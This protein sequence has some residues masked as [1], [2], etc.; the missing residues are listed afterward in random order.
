VP[1][2]PTCSAQRINLFHGLSESQFSWI[3]ERLYFRTFPP[4]AVIMTAQQPGEMV[5]LIQSGTVKIHLEQADGTDVILAILGPG[6]MVGEMSVLDSTV[7]SA[8]VVTLE[9][10]VLCWMGQ[11]AFQECLRKFPQV[12]ENL[13]RILA[14]R[15][16]LSNELVQALASLD[17]HGRVARQLL[18]FAEKYGQALP[19]EGLRI[20]LRLTQS[21]LADL[22]GASRKRVNQAMVLFK[23]QGLL[24]TDGEGR[25]TLHDRQSLAAY[26]RQS[27]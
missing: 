15:V 8:S 26:C 27:P 5:Y 17:V 14:G 10:S 12:N 16:R 9:E 18:V 1:A 7:R 20:P 23:N 6:E 24:S 21:D 2:N 22:V 4:G 11:D 19:S 3:S 13:S 25:I